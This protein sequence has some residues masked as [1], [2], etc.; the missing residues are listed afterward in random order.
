VAG[1]NKIYVA[2]VLML[3]ISLVIIQHF[4]PVQS[5]WKLSF[6]GYRK[7]PYGCSIAR[8]LFPELFPGQSVT[9][10]VSSFYAS[11]PP[12]TLERKNLVIINEAFDPEEHDLS[13][14]LNF[15]SEGNSVFIS[16][17]GFSDKLC[18][19]LG[20]KIITQV[21]DTS[22]FKPGEEVLKLSDPDKSSD[23]AFVFRKRFMESRFEGFDSLRSI[24]LGMDRKGS[25]NFIVMS[26]G[27]GKIFLH[28]QPLAFTN[29]HLLYSNY[30]YACS[31]LTQLPVVATIW[32]QYYKQDR[33]A[34]SSPVRYILSQAPLRAAYFLLIGTLLIYM[35]IGSRR[36]QRA[37]PV[38]TPE[39]NSSLGFI[40][41]V[42]KLY[43][44]SRNNADL[45]RKKIT[46]FNEF[47]KNRY[48]I[49]KP[50]LRDENVRILWQRSGIEESSIKDLLKL[51]S[52]LS[53]R[54]KIT[55]QELIGLHEAIE[56]FYRHC[57]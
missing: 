41:T 4:V 38:V 23:S 28:C 25:V 3:F 20:F 37:I 53:K 21:V 39:K 10:N 24:P 35:V 51:L 52:G 2:I 12:D 31:A 9:D 11:L 22:F 50:E 54:I 1:K 43:Y 32:D 6:N 48:S 18:D 56:D 46:Y 34:D 57:K 44:R 33:E 14:L 16:S 17:S 5:D 13:A 42:G 36:M 8:D 30:Q 19:T 15:A 26:F 27:N 49:E 7:S 40:V 55:D 45:A 47:V 29:Y